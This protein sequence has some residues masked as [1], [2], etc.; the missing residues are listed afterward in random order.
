[1][2]QL[3]ILVLLFILSACAG[4]FDDDMFIWDENVENPFYG[5]TLTIAVAH[6][7][8]MWRFINMFEQDNPGVEIELI[9]LGYDFDTIRERIGVQLMAGEAPLLMNSNFVDMRNRGLFVN[10][11]PLIEAHPRF[12][13]DEWFM[14]IFYALAE[15]GKLFEL[16]E[17]ISYQA[18]S[19][20]KNVQGLVEK[21]GQIYDGISGLS[22]GA[23]PINR[24]RFEHCLRRDIGMMLWNFNRPDLRLKISH[25]EAVEYI[26]YQVRH[27]MDRPMAARQDVPISIGLFFNELWDELNLGI[28]SPHEAA[29]MLQNRVMLEILEGN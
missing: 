3:L 10:W 26:H 13:D 22:W 11:M 9:V 25:D 17:S 12:N 6:R 14:D 23:V 21:L 24:A 28:I 18:Y 16:P 15:D 27:E 2:K 19:G 1:M 8:P 7:D 29:N 4:R 5:E 20:N